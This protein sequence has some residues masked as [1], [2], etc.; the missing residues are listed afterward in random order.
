MNRSR[1]LS[2]LLSAVLTAALYG[3]A[4]YLPFFFDDL[5]HMPFVAATGLLDIWGSSGGFP[6]YRPLGAT[7]WRVFYKVLNENNPL[8]L[9]AFNLILHIANGTLIGLIVAKFSQKN[10]RLRWAAPLAASFFIVFP[11]SYQAVPWIGAAYHLLAASLI[12][13]AVYAVICRVDRPSNSYLV[14]GIGAAFLAPFAHEN[15]VVLPLLLP[16]AA[17]LYRPSR[18]K[19]TPASLAIWTAPTAAWLLIWLLVPKGRSDGFFPI[20]FEAVWQN[21]VYFLQGLTFPTTIFTGRL[22]SQGGWHDFTTTYLFAAVGIL[23]IIIGYRTAKK[24]LQRMMLFGLGWFVVSSLPAVFSLDFA[25]TLSSPRLLMIPS[26]GIA[27]VWA[28]V[29][30][31]LWESSRYKTVVRSFSVGLAGYIVAASSW[32]IVV[33]MNQHETLGRIWQQAADIAVE[34]NRPGFDTV[35]V[36]VNLPSALVERQLFFPIGH[37]G[38]V[39]MVPYIPLERIIDSQL[40]YSATAVFRAYEDIRPQR[41]YLYDVL[42]SGR[43]WPEILSDYPRVDIWV[44]DYFEDDVQLRLIGSSITPTRPTFPF[45]FEE[46]DSSILLA[47]AVREEQKISVEI[48]WRVGE[49][50]PSFEWT[51]FVHLLDDQGQLIAQA[52]GHPWGSTYP[53]GQWPPAAQHIDLRTIMIPEG[54]AE[55]VTVQIGLY[56]NVSG[57]RATVILPDGE[58]ADALTLNVANE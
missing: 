34:A 53:L 21:T 30:C 1:S 38:T 18:F 6:Y 24:Q 25:Y 55:E 26:V 36:F 33:H 54:T 41:D 27:T 44:T 37:E 50:A 12:L 9:H 49:S 19:I 5:D 8:V 40:G 57:E 58:A 13:A 51:A 7:I 17:F 32:M 28:G 10:E 52:D 3:R 56:S 20:N 48:V 2:L 42:G 46:L 15:G 29:I 22:V 47:S 11:F 39:F 43:D 45:V 16:L 14:L 31:A 35:P 23:L 4:V